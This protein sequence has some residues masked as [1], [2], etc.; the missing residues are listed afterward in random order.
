MD[1]PLARAVA[2]AADRQGLAAELGALRV[3][4]A[5]LLTEALNADDPTRLAT[6]ASQLANAAARVA[7]PHHALV[8]PPD[9]LQDALMQALTDLNL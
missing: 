7:R 9:P 3:L 4:L 2:Q 5:R 1:V 6:A 8:P